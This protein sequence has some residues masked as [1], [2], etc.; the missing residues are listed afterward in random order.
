MSQIV[1]A[2]IAYT[3]ALTAQRMSQ[4]NQQDH[5]A[6]VK[7]LR[8]AYGRG[9]RI[10]TDAHAILDSVLVSQNTTELTL[11]CAWQV[12][13]IGRPQELNRRSMILLIT[14]RHSC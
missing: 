1:N 10:S 5:G 12:A 6:A 11:L 7:L 3:D 2:A 9:L 14:L 8:A 13:P 4:V